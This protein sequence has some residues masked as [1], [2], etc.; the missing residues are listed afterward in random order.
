MLCLLAAAS[1][2]F[3]VQGEIKMSNLENEVRSVIRDFVAQGELFT[4]LD[5]SNKVKLVVPFARHNDVSELVR[6]LFSTEIESSG[7]GRSPIDVT[8]TDGSK[9]TAMLYH[10]L[11]DTWDLD[12]KYDAQKRAQ[13]SFKPVQAAQAVVTAAQVANN[14]VVVPV[15]P[16]AAPPIVVPV[17]NPSARAQ[18]DNLFKTQPS[19]FPRK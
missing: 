7:Y 2:S 17:V 11:A 1:T 5:V 14:P 9:R 10:S 4:G 19:L 3:A 13:I 6:K 8:L 12:N 15:A 18:W 16:V